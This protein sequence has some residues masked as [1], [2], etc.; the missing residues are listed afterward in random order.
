MIRRLSTLVIAGVLSV[1]TVCAFA[2]TSDSAPPWKG[3]HDHATQWEHVHARHTEKLKAL[4]HI[5][6]AQENDWATFA[7][8]MKPPVGMHHEHPDFAALDKL[9][10]PE[11]IEKMHALRK[12]RMAAMDMAMTQHEEAIKTFYAALT[13]E[14]KKTFDEH[15]AKHVGR[16]HKHHERW[17]QGDHCEPHRNGN[18]NSNGDAK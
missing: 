10:T 3:N 1:S 12:E 6:P 2:Q 9:S 15:F 8:A 7:A 14:Q 16:F 18:G 17:S 4:L 13:L 11:R 5:T